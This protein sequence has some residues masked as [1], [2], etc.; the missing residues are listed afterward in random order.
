MTVSMLT[1]TQ[2]C[3]TTDEDLKAHVLFCCSCA[4]PS[5]L[6]FLS[7]LLSSKTCL[8]YRCKNNISVQRTRCHLQQLRGHSQVGQNI[9]HAFSYTDIDTIW[10]KHVFPPTKIPQHASH[11][12]YCP[13]C[14]S[15]GG[16][17]GTPACYRPLLDNLWFSGYALNKG[18]FWITLKITTLLL[19]KM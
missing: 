13:W 5:M 19:W 12:S 2:I 18:W 4:T 3:M 6:F 8:K 9:Q 16:L 17:A 11:H 15:V 10:S 14:Q 7:V 1:H